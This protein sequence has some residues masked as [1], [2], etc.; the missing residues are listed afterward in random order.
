MA[1]HCRNCGAELIPG[2]RFCRMCGTEIAQPRSEEVPTQIL[3][4]DRDADTVINT[5]PTPRLGT[6]PIY[7]PPLTERQPLVAYQQT[8][9]LYAP[10]KPRSSWPKWVIA[11]G[12]IGVIGIALLAVLIFANSAPPVRVRMMPPKEMHPGRP[13]GVPVER[14]ETKV[15]TVENT[16]G[17][18]QGDVITKSFPLGKTAAISLKNVAGDITIEGWDEPQAVVKIIKS[19]GSEQ[20]RKAVSISLSS[21]GKNLS[22]ASLP[23]SSNKVEVSYEIKLPRRI[24]QLGIASSK[25]EVKLSNISGMIGVDLQAGSIELSD[26]SGTVK[27]NIMKGDTKVIF[28]EVAQDGPKE[29]SS[30]RGNIELQL[31]SDINADVKAETTDGKIEFD[32][33]LGLKVERRI[34]GE[35]AVG[36][37]G[38]G[39]EPFLIKTV[40]GN[41]KLSK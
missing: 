41:I 5:A 36:R 33:E 8:T 24:R 39:G 38:E 13:P 19:G 15:A 6:D 23:S 40:K 11:F 28:D 34:V 9:P 14:A 25:S 27:T 16:I 31:N 3:P 29:F 10:A 37:I 17:P 20:E 12:L 7:S 30:I 2:H 4:V 18:E 35:H 32:K 21:D 26:V 1:E 22:L